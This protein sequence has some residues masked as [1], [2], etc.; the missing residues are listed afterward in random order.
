MAT[1]L[2]QLKVGTRDFADQLASCTIAL[3][4]CGYKGTYTSVEES[5][6]TRLVNHSECKSDPPPVLTE[7]VIIARYFTT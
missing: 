2:A 6:G 5:L 3:T 7:V 1:L 4:L